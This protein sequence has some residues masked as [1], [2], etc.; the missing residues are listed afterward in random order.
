MKMKIGWFALLLPLVIAVPTGQGL[1]QDEAQEKHVEQ[2][3]AE[4]QQ[5]QERTFES[6]LCQ[7]ALASPGHYYIHQ[8]DVTPGSLESNLSA[9]MQKSDEVVLIT[10]AIP[11]KADVLSP[12]G[13][14]AVSYWDAVVLRTWKGQH[15]VGDLI[16]FA[17]PSD[18]RV[19]CNIGGTVTAGTS[20]GRDDPTQSKTPLTPISDGPFVLFLKR[21]GGDEAT[22]MPELRPTGGGGAQ[23]VFSFNREDSPNCA[24]VQFMG[25]VGGC[26]KG[27]KFNYIPSCNSDLD[28]DTAPVLV[29]EVQGP[30]GKKYDGMPISDFLREVQ[31]VADGLGQAAASK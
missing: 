7:R 6:P 13:N 14:D 29:K 31:S 23:G 12:S 21:S 27:V 20:V 8:L 5:Q 18:G 11:G 26:T 16:T 30:L 28:A 15:K 17:L 1:A 2:I 9:M 22:M 3:R 24:C 25:K 10:S 4:Q 19:N